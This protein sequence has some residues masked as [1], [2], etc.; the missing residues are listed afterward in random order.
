MNSKSEQS[1]TKLVESILSNVNLKK[2]IH[3]LSYFLF[4]FT[5]LSLS[6]ETALKSGAASSYSDLLTPIT[7]SFY[8][9]RF[10]LFLIPS[11]V[12][13]LLS[14]HKKKQYDFILKGLFLFMA[15]II[16]SRN[17]DIFST[18]NLIPNLNQSK[19]FIPLYH[20]VTAVNAAIW[21]GIIIL[22]IMWMFQN[23]NYMHYKN[24]LE[25]KA[26]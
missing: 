25:S 14:A 21:M 6:F 15:P 24:N 23:N 11:I 17:M 8:W 3:Y 10:I 22:G 16:V 19:H 9:P 18:Y 26:Y 12:L 7:Y 5:F 1:V 20:F 13:I 2:K 4:I